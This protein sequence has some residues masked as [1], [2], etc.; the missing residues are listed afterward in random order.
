[1]R[2]AYIWVR[3]C[4]RTRHFV[5]TTK[6]TSGS[7]PKR[8]TTVSTLFRMIDIIRAR[9]D[10]VD[11]FWYLSDAT[12]CLT[13]KGHWYYK[14]ANKPIN[15]RTSPGTICKCCCSLKPTPNTFLRKLGNYWG[16]SFPVQLK[17][18]WNWQDSFDARRKAKF[19]CDA[20]C[21][22]RWGTFVRKF[23]LLSSCRFP[24]SEF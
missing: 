3:I 4:T 15:A 16:K 17:I 5:F 22:F 18:A 7:R 21:R 20:L 8:R 6:T 23:L 2:P 1:M 13:N 19:E 9:T 14:W 11:R 12:V 24:A 10:S